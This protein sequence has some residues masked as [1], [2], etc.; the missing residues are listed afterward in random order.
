M[1]KT[2]ATLLVLVVVSLGAIGCGSNASDPKNV[3]SSNPIVVTNRVVDYG[4]GVYYF[5][6]RM[7]DFGNELSH[8]LKAHPDLEV[9]AM[10]GD[11]GNTAYGITVGY[12]VTFKPKPGRNT[13]WPQ[14]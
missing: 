3:T 11:D 13:D 10:A 2:L 4:N 9:T 7:K 14:K 6:W 12:F 1:K 5:T 8:F